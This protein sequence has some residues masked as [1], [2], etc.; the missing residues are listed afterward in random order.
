MSDPALRATDYHPEQLERV[1]SVCLYVA[2]LLGDL[3][4]RDLVI[5]GGL[6]PSLIID[7]SRL[8]AGEAHVGTADLDVGL[9]LALLGEGRY[10]RVARWPESVFR[11]AVDVDGVPVADVIQC[12]LDV[13]GEQARGAEQAAFI[14]TRVLGP[15]IANGEPEP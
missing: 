14:W 9:A 13:S 11:A 2:T 4:A 3:M 5:V 10:R 15:A 8:P 6:V 1:R 12:W 7:Q